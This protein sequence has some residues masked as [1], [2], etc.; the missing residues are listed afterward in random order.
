MAR[1]QA[2]EIEKEEE[3]KETQSAQSFNTSCTVLLVLGTGDPV[4]V[5]TSFVVKTC[6]HNILAPF[7]ACLDKEHLNLSPARTF[8]MK[9]CRSF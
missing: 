1:E 9:A 5:G 8:S 6:E 7:T 2:E 3:E 4:T